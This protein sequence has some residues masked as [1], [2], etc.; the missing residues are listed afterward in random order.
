M[1]KNILLVSIGG[2]I[3]SALRYLCQKWVYQLYPLTFPWGT[4]LVNI[5]GCFL[6]GVFFAASEKS[7]VI[8][9]DWRLFLTTG[10]CGGFTTFSAFAFENMNL[11][12]T[13]DVSYSLLYAASSVILGIIAVFA[14]IAL[15][16]VL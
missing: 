5:L 11:L 10:I 3:G 1:I 8:S 14:G 13:G 4:F 12:R 7:A 2:G 9:A 15:I 6:I 16:K